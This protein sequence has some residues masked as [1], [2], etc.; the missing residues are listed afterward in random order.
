MPLAVVPLSL[1][2]MSQRK[3][4]INPPA[5]TQLQSAQKPQHLPFCTVSASLYPPLALR[6]PEWAC[7]SLRRP[8]VILLALCVSY[9]G[10]SEALRNSWLP[11]CGPA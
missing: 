3:P 6:H 5:A 7:V 9:A 1:R 4:H 11:L 2:Q 8:C 10:L